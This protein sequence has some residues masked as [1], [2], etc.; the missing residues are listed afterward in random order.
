VGQDDQLKILLYGHP[1]ILLDVNKSIISITANFIEI[2]LT[3]INYLNL[4]LGAD[5][6]KFPLSANFM[7]VLY[8][9]KLN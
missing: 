8:R 7:K 2:L 1:N 5:K 6:S 4:L 9:I 3:E